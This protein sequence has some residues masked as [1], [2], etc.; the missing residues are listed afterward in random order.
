LDG[1]VLGD[2]DWDWRAVAFEQ[3]VEE[4]AY[5]ATARR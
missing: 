2:F 3:V 5:Q 4:A 1:W